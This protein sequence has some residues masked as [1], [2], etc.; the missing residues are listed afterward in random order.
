MS[1]TPLPGWPFAESPFHGSERAVQ[2]RL[3]VREKLEGRGRLVIR[4][5]MPEQHRDFFRQLPFVIIGSL[6]R[7]GQPWASV[8]AGPPG[9]VASPDPRHLTIQAQPLCSDPLHAGLFVNANIG[10]L[11]IEPHTRRRNRMNGKVEQLTD[12]GFTLRVDQSYGNCPKYIQARHAQFAAV[13]DATAASEPAPPVHRSDQLDA[14]MRQLIGAADTF[15]IATAFTGDGADDDRRRGVDVSHRGGK[16]GFVRIDDART[17]T[18]PDFVGNYFFNTLGNIV[19]HPSAGLL[20]IDF[21]TGDLLHMAVDVEVIWDGDEVKAFD[22]AQRL[23]R[24]H[25]RQA[26]RVE[27]CLSLRWS[28]EAE[29]SPVLKQTGSWDDAQSRLTAAK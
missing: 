1:D 9:F 27:R 8:L 10:L 26:L 13:A 17:L 11:G 15:F 5:F 3:G 7:D 20:F 2:E 18:F 22:G 29:L 24:L 4:D 23:L 14:A 25:I 21:V 16:P 6:D 12:E 19:A 28:E